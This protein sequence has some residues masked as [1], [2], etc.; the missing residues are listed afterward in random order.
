MNTA[1]QTSLFRPVRFYP[2]EREVFRKKE[3]LTPSERAEKYRVVTMGAHMGPWRNDITPYLAPIMDAWAL[4]HVREVVICK[5]PQTGGTEAMYNCMSYAMDHDP[6]TDMV[7]MPSQDMARKV[8]EDRIIPMLKQDLRLRDFISENPDDTAKQRV[9]LRNGEILYMAWANSASAVATFPVKRLYFDETDKYPATVGREADPISLGEKRARTFRYTSKNFKVSTPTREEGPIWKG[10]NRCDVVYHFHAR[11]PSCGC[12]QVFKLDQLRYPSDKTPEEVRREHTA[13]YDCEGCG[14]EWTDRQRDAA[15]RSGRWKAVKGENIARPRRVGFHLPSW[16]SPDVSL[17]EIAAAYMNTK[18][19]RAKLIDFYNDYLAEP[20]I[21]SQEG[22]GVDDRALAG[23]RED[24]GPELPMGVAILTGAADV[25]T[26]RIEYEVDGW[27]KG[28]ESWGIELKVFIG[29]TKLPEVWAEFDAY[30]KKTYRHES[31]ADLRVS[32]IC[33][34]TGDGNTM[35]QACD[36]IRPRQS[37]RI[38]GVKGSSRPGQ[39]II[40][41]RPSFKNK[42]K[43]ALFFVGTDTAKSTIHSNLQLDEFGPG[44]MHYHAGFDDEYF[45]QLT[46]EKVVVKYHK[47]FTKREWVKVRPRNEAFDLRVYNLAALEILKTYRNF[48][49]DRLA[50]EMEARGPAA[51]PEAEAESVEK[52]DKEKLA[53]LV[54]Q[55]TAISRATGRRKGGWV[56]GW[57]R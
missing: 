23:R 31:G 9:R 20:F 15:V 45:K 17:S 57:R 3:D 35:K 26:N 56:K 6:S 36:Y 39:P 12:E 16:L 29:D 50:G 41:G 13:R 5:S 51:A 28:E 24:Y 52:A 2:A 43:I 4:P 30:R 46:A 11:C 8:S 27:G 44:Y 40:T 34:D 37:Q 38:Y 32:C 54:V 21:E 53:A 47:G 7:I 14:V 48:S 18:I 25:Q 49:L 22:E 33:I 19:D 42:G 55:T 10:L 1:T